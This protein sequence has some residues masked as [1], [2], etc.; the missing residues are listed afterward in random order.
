MHV[1]AASQTKETCSDGARPTENVLF[2]S[3]SV[4]HLLEKGN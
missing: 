3:H 1:A 4:H 2:I